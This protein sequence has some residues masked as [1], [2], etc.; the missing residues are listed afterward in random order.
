MYVCVTVC[1]RFTIK[2]HIFVYVPFLAHETHDA[3]AYT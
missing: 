2:I 3:H 1:N